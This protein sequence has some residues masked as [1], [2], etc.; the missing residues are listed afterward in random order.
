MSIDD[1]AGEA[2]V[3]PARIDATLQPFQSLDPD[4][5]L[6]RAQSSLAPPE[7]V[8]LTL[9][10]STLTANGPAP[11][12]WRQRAPLLASSLP[13]ID[14]LEMISPAWDAAAAE[15]TDLSDHQFFFSDGT[16]LVEAT[17]LTR[18]TERLSAL[19]GE[20]ASLGVSLEVSVIGLTDGSGTSQFNTRLADQRIEVVS[21]GLV[22]NGVPAEIIS[23]RRDVAEAGGFDA[24]LRRVDVRLSASPDFD[25]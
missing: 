10:G 7:G 19:H 20:S 18:Y 13:G 16:T 15:F 22:A 1:I 24:N 12:D 6:R 4:I 3:D 8:T 14:G 17:E 21:R 2:N 25:Q 11:G 23:S 9:S 5:V